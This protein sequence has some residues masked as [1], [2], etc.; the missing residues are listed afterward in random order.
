VKFNP[1]W[2]Q[3]ALLTVLLASVIVTHMIAP[4]AVSAITS[5]VST[6]V[7]ALFVNL[8]S[9]PIFTVAK[10]GLIP[11]PQDNLVLPTKDSNGGD[12]S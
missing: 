7:G 8:K 4:G 9:G 3:V 6:I 10:G 5:I 12:E 1:T 2:Q 11:T